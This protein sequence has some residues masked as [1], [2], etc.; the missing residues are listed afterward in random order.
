MDGCGQ[1]LAAPP[2]LHLTLDYISWYRSQADRNLYPRQSYAVKGA[3]SDARSLF[4]SPLAGEQVLYAAFLRESCFP[5]IPW[6]H[7]WPPSWLRAGQG[8]LFQKL[9]SRRSCLHLP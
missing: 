7:P 4:R 9:N 2:Y 6:E 3:Y 5:E 1:S 8:R